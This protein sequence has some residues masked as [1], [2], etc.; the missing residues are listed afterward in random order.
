MAVSR[1]VRL[2]INSPSEE[3]VTL[4]D[5]LR[6][7]Y[8]LKKRDGQRSRYMMYVFWGLWTFQ[9]PTQWYIARQYLFPYLLHDFTDQTQHF[10]ESLYLF[11]IVEALLNLFCS[12][13]FN[14]I[15]V[16][17]RDTTGDH[18]SR[19]PG[20]SSEPVLHLNGHLP[21]DGGLPW[22]YCDKCDIMI[23]PRA[24]HCKI[25]NV[26]ILKRDH[27]CFVLG[28]CIGHY[29]QRYFVVLTFYATI[30]GLGGVILTISYLR[31]FYWPDAVWTDFLFPITIFRGLFG[32]MESHIAIM[33]IHIYTETAIGILGI[34]F[35]PSQIVSIFKGVTLF[36][37]MKGVSV[38]NTNSVN[39]NF[40]SVFGNFW[41]LNFIFPMTFIYRQKDGTSWKG[42][43]F[44]YNFKQRT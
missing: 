44:N 29:N 11:C 8:E 19:D 9:A 24:H 38:L 10:M 4:M 1:S 39:A 26:C 6:Q 20:K 28:K 40:V 3:P 23:P 14:S 2:D 25:C 12:S 42:V 30:V 32:T 36:E 31:L 27:H 7:H 34:I 43:K 21:D 16:K 41:A 5:K 33:I 17:T 37:M 13:I 22:R 35:F 15:Y 18:S